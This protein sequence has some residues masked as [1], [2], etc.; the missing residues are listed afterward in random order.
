V[1]GRDRVARL[2]AGFAPAWWSG[3]TLTWLETNGEPSALIRRGEESLAVLSIGTS[4]AGIERL[5]WV[6]APAKLAHLAR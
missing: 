4:T 5:L 2:V 3:T 6:M 1:V